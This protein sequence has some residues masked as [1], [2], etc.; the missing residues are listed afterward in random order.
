MADEKDEDQTRGSD[1]SSP[2]DPADE[3]A[4]GAGVP[5]E[6]NAEL[7][8]E[9]VGDGQPGPVDVPEDAA[10]AGEDPAEA[11]E[12]PETVDEP[13]LVGARG[14]RRPVR[15]TPEGGETERKGRATRRRGDDDDDTARRTGPVTFVNE[16]V[17]EL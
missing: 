11:G 14:S 5:V 7:S 13:A 8:P 12:E 3:R 15:R 17:G 1:P 4:D 9:P 10:E 2:R 16:S 6:A